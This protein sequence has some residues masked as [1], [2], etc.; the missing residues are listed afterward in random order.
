MMSNAEIFSVGQ[1]VKVLNWS[2]RGSPSGR[3]GLVIE[4]VYDQL[5]S[6]LYT[7]SDRATMVSESRLRTIN[8]SSIQSNDI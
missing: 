5:Y 1:L 4:I 8:W 2:K 6:V 7:N 3:V